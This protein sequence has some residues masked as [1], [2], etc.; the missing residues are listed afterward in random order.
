[1]LLPVELS[2][3][4]ECRFVLKTNKM[5]PN[6]NN[7]YRQGGR[8]GLSHSLFC[9]ENSFTVAPAVLELASRL[10]GWRNDPAVKS[11]YC[12][13][14]VWSQASSIQVRQ[15]T[16]TSNSSSRVSEAI[17]FETPLPRGHSVGRR[18]CTD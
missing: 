1:V 12:S 8:K 9:F 5:L 7:Q 15:L 11:L 6:V 16:A 18:K 10:G 2:Q 17:S 4:E 3:G 14:R 13:S